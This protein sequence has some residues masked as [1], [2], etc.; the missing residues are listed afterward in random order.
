MNCEMI[1]E[2]LGSQE[3]RMRYVPE[4]RTFVATSNKF[5]GYIRHFVG[6]YGWI[7]GFGTP[8]AEHIDVMVPTA[9]EYSLGSTVRIRIVG[10]FKRSDGDDKYVAIEATRQEQTLS[11]LPESERLMLFR[12]Y[13][14]V[15]EHGAWLEHRAASSKLQAWTSSGGTPRIEACRRT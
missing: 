12:Q 10:C 6:I 13:P 3:Y 5:L 11:E 4:S 7:V 15:R 8:P 2:Q 9:N 14:D 1:V